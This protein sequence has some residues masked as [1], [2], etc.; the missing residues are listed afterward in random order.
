M[1][2]QLLCGAQQLSEC[3]FS[4][5]MGSDERVVLDP[6]PLLSER[7]SCRSGLARSLNSSSPTPSKP[8]AENRSSVPTVNAQREAYPER[9]PVPGGSATVT[10]H[11]PFEKEIL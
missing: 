4:L 7:F 5:R 8:S 6:R 3:K 11:A 2:A 9:G 1:P 10:A